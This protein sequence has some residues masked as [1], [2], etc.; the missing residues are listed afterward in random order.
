MIGYVL[1]GTNNFA[2]A[3]RFFDELLADIGAKRMDDLE[4]MCSWSTGPGHGVL[5]VVKPF[6]GKPATVG[7]GSMASIPLRNRA[8]VNK[9]HAKALSLGAANE[10]DPGVRAVV[11][12][13][14]F[15]AAYFRDLDGN[16]FAAVSFGPE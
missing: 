4:K 10:G 9:F 8:E 1:V 7:N 11:N 12:G 5:A 3:K 14:D 16:K 6:D 2:E 15:Y 13:Q